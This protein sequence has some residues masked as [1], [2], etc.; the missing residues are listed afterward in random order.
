MVSNKQDISQANPTPCLQ[1]LSTEELIPGEAALMDIIRGSTYSRKNKEII[2]VH[3]GN[4][5]IIEKNH[6]KHVDHYHKERSTGRVVKGK[7]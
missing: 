6:K 4:F 5:F 3:C 7:K 2:C 1:S